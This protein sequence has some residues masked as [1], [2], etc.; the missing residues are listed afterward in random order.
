M[1]RK[2]APVFA[3]PIVNLLNEAVDEEMMHC[4]PVFISERIRA[5]AIY[6]EFAEFFP[7]IDIVFF[8]E[9]S[10]IDSILV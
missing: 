10:F 9:I 2:H 8:F 5:V 1:P 4:V 6:E 3:A 7:K